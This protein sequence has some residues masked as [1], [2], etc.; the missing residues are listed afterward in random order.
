MPRM[1]PRPSTSGRHT[2]M[3]GPAIVADI[4]QH[5]DALVLVVTGEVDV[6]TAPQLGLA[7]E[8][9]VFASRK[10]ALTD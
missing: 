5:N 1:D 7:D 4:Q 6:L 3:P 2:S 8:L 10:D 9:A